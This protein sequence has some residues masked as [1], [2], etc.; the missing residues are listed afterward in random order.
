MQRLIERLDEMP[1][2]AYDAT[3]TEGQA[4]PFHAEPKRLSHPVFGAFCLDGD[5]LSAAE[6]D[7]RVVVYAAARGSAGELVLRSLT[8]R[9][10]TGS[11]AR[12]TFTRPLPSLRPLPSPRPWPLYR[13]LPFHR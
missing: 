3:W 11:A 8:R 13:P 1:F 4:R 5:V 10:R 2:A 7:T 6:G 9:R 12:L